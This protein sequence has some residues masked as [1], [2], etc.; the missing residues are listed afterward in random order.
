MSFKEK[1]RKLLN[2]S[3]KLKLYVD[4]DDTILDSLSSMVSYLNSL[5]KRDPMKKEDVA[6]WDYFKK[7]FSDKEI[8]DSFANTVDSAGFK[9]N[10]EQAFKRLL[11]NPKLD[12]YILTA[13]SKPFQERRVE[14]VKKNMSYFPIE[15]LIFS[16]DKHEY[17]D[18]ILIDDGM[19]NIEK[20]PGL[21]FIV[22]MPHNKSEKLDK[23]TVRI[24]NLS[25][26]LEYFKGDDRVRKK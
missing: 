6:T 23:D 7:W 2:K 20:Y 16:H 15:K 25:E 22:T 1:L 14:W 17:G 11:S 18:G 3:G 26:V 13:T 12:V 8:E 9:P 4:M 10:T 21:K 24:N 5:G 19:H